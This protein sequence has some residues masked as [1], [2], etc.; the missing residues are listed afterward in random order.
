MAEC[1]GCS[2]LG[3]NDQ[4]VRAR[5]HVRLLRAGL[6]RTTRAQVPLLE[7]TS[8]SPSTGQPARRTHT[9]TH[10]HARTHTRLTAV[11]PGLYPGEPVPE[12]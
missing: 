11:C 5:A 2:M 6:T 9:H 1:A 10:T 12:R 8:H 4:L 7:E 3:G